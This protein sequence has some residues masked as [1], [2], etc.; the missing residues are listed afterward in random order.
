M[1]KTLNITEIE[2]NGRIYFIPDKYLENTTIENIKLY[3]FILA[4]IFDSNLEKGAL[5][6]CKITKSILNTY[7][8]SCDKIFAYVI[9]GKLNNI[10]LTTIEN[11]IIKHIPDT[12]IP[13]L[14]PNIVERLE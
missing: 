10:H 2:I 11:N 12:L 13:K 1:V 3:K 14:N 8:Q 7:I 4:S 5:D 6:L 9:T